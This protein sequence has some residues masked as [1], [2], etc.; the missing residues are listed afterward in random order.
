MENRIVG[1]ETLINHFIDMIG[2][3]KLSHGYLF[4]GPAGLGKKL[5]ARYLAKVL[6]CENSDTEPCGSCDSCMQFDSGN[7]PDFFEH[8]PDGSRFKREQIDLIQKEMSVRPFGDKKVFILESADNMTIQAQNTFLKTLEEPP[9]YVVIFMVATNAQRLL[10]TILSRCQEIAFYPIE[11]SDIEEYLVEKY[12][13]EV[14]RARLLSSYSNGIIGKAVLFATDDSFEDR[15][16]HILNLI[17]EVLGG[18]L[19]MVLKMS[20]ELQDKK[21]EINDII[22]LFRIYFRDL[23]IVKMTGTVDQIINS[24]Y[25]EILYK[26]SQRVS[27]DGLFKIIDA[28]EALDKDL[29]YNINYTAAID[30]LLLTMQEV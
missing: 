13:I 12:K 20:N 21:S 29:K 2:S 9:E 8:V 4:K 16:A 3:K 22:E 5:T 14:S 15:R 27:R 10:P 24:D 28:I 30:Q 23:L 1:H 6:L 7:H 18:T 25:K 11:Q 26:Q 19:L 17:D